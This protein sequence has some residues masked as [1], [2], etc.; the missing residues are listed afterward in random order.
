MQVSMHL[1]GGGPVIEY[2]MDARVCVCV[3]G[4]MDV[5]LVTPTY[6]LR[7]R[8]YMRA[9]MTNDGGPSVQRL[10]AA[11]SYLHGHP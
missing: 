8:A 6:G 4:G 2:G 5:L 9:C 11:L 7:A 1:H 10:E 3:C